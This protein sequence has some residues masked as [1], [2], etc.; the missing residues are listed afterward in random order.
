MIK[1]MLLSGLLATANLFAIGEA[2]VAGA[3]AAIKL[4]KPKRYTDERVLSGVKAA[5]PDYGLD[6][7]GIHGA[8]GS[9]CHN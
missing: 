4:S 9:V 6:F 7:S 2:S 1:K 3:D 5:L 8:I